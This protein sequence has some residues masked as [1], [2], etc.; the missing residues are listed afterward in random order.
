VI[1]VFG[2]LLL[3]WYLNYMSKAGKTEMSKDDNYDL[4]FCL[5]IGVVAGARLFQVLIWQPW[6]YFSNPLEIIMIWKGGLS[7]HGGLAGAVAAAWWFSKQ[8]KQSFLHIADLVTIPAVFVLALGRIGNFINGELW[9]T[10]T[11]VPWCVKFKGA[12]GCRHPVQIYGALGRFL[13]GGLL[14]L[15]N[16]EKRKEGFIFLVFMLL[17]GAGRLF[18]DFLR[19]DP[20]ILG[21]STG[22]YLSIATII[23]AGYFL[24]RFYKQEL[25]RFPFYS[26]N[27]S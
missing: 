13:L 14:L 20:R 3:L 24:I 27:K 17:I 12:E 10:V 11:N 26:Y 2:F 22:Q 16:K 8:K 18:I 4:V 15:Y 9:G 21:L 5:I 1:Y 19:E 7:F 25:K 23:I 6:Y